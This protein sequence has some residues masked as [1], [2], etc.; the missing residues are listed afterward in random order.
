MELQG[1]VIEIIYKNEIN[2]YCIAVLNIDKDWIKSGNKQSDQ[3]DLLSME[4]EIDKL[5]N[6]TTIVGYLP[7]VNIGDTLKVVGKF[8]EHQEYG[9]QFK[10]DTFEKKMPQTT[11]ALERY[12]ANCGIKG[13]G[14]ATAK[15]IVDMFGEDTLNVFKFEPEKLS[16]VK[17]ITKDKAVEIANTFIENWEVW[18]LVGFLDKFG[19][20]PQSAEKIYKALGANAIEEIEANPYILIDLVNKVNFT[21]ID[22]M[23]LGLGIEY[24]NEKRIRSGI[25]HALLLM[26]YNGHCCTRYESLV[27][28][29]KKLLNVSENEIE[30]CLI[31]MKA[32]EDIVLEERD[33]AEWVYLY[34][35]YKAE[36]EVAER[37]IDLNTYKNIKKID[38]FDK[39]L[40]LFEKKSSIELSEK[41]IE[42]IRAI[43]E[44]NVCVITGGPGTGKTTIIKTIIDIFKHN[45][46]KPVLCAPTGRAAKKMTETTG[47]DAKTLHRLLEIGK[48][49]DEDQGLN[50]EISVAPIDGDI[51]IVDEMSMV[52]LFLMNYLCKALYKGTKLVLVGDIDQ[53][54]SVGPGNVLKDIIESGKITTIRLN[55][56]FRQAARSK[57]IVNAHRVNEGIG[58]ITKQEIQDM[59]MIIDNSV[60]SKSE[61]DREINRKNTDKITN[62]FLDDFFFVDQRDKEK[63]LYNIITLSGERLKKYGDYDFLKNIQVITPTKKGELGTKELNKILQQT[64]NPWTETKN[65]KKFGDNTFREGDRIMQIKNNYDIYWEKKEPYFESGSGVF[66]GE[67]GTINII[68]DFNKQ[69]KIKFDDEKEVWYQYNE[70]EQIEHAYAI[71][72]HKAQG[73]EFDVVIMPISQ[74]APMLLTRNLLYTGM[75]RAKKLLIIIGNK[76]IVDFMINNSDNKKRNTGL[77]YKLRTRNS[78]VVER[79][80]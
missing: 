10:V 73:S 37:L 46:M 77:A 30:D 23:A 27:E 75:T 41:Q 80:Y 52:D 4:R 42:A 54:P 17:G 45:E 5:D 55:K 1:E 56:I 2:S 7:F 38:R 39:E 64:V 67:F 8:V 72:V 26:T 53:L 12:L 24:N 44:N 22:K 15:H 51:V 3:M 49:S 29:V 14:P 11:K 63:I 20:G 69:I 48:F 28:F 31:N 6:E 66:N 60:E 78:G 13:V 57:I 59:N 61:E 9:R 50:V 43:N 32:K 25:K 40:K 47:N 70:L 76:N 58:F 35:Y 19:I 74:T 36:Q 68:D 18:Q 33:E 71:T 62:I 21:Q 16:R 34:Q 65:E 79:R